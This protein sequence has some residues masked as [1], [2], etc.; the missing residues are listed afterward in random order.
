[1]NKYLAEISIVKETSKIYI[2]L[3]VCLLLTAIISM[4]YQFSRQVVI[5]PALFNMNQK[6]SIMSK[7]KT[8]L[9]INPPFYSL[10]FQ[11]G[12]LGFIDAGCDVS[13]CV[14]TSNHSYVND[15]NFDAFMFHVPLQSKARW[16][17]P[18]RRNDQIFIF[19]GLEPPG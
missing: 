5:H 9:L 6:S 13:N 15:Y 1:M 7:T 18:N 11:E 4:T 2:K 16:R 14:L 19:F 12:R 3:L 8:V 10:R 17:L